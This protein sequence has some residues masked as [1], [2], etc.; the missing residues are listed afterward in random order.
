MISEEKYFSYVLLTIEIT[1]QIPL[2]D[3]LYFVRYWAKS[4][5]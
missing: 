5:L 3:C 4:A 2:S 1:D